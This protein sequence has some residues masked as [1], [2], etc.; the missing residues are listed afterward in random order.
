[1]QTRLILFP[2]APECCGQRWAPPHLV[3]VV[4]LFRCVCGWVCGYRWTRTYVQIHEDLTC[5][6]GTPSTLVLSFPCGERVCVLVF[7]HPWSLRGSLAEP[8]AR[9]AG[10]KLQ[11][12]SCLCL[13]QSCCCRCLRVDTPSFLTPVL[14]LS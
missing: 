2:L 9:P 6:L 10:S 7:V 4:S 11:K 3:Q 5:S 8:G 1:M 13:P 12:S 14:T